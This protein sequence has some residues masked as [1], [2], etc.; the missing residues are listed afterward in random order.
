MDTEEFHHHCPGC[1]EKLND[2]SDVLEHL[3]AEGQSPNNL[4]RQHLFTHHQEFDEDIGDAL[5]RHAG[6]HQGKEA[7]LSL[8]IPHTHAGYETFGRAGI[9]NE[10]QLPSGFQSP[11]FRVWTND[12]GSASGKRSNDRIESLAGGYSHPYSGIKAR[13]FHYK[14]HNRMIG[15]QNNTGIWSDADDY[16]VRFH[17][18][19]IVS[20]HHNG[21]EMSLRG[22]GWSEAPSTRGRMN[23][24]TPRGYRIDQNKVD[25]GS[26]KEDVRNR[27]DED[28]EAKIRTVHHWQSTGTVTTPNDE[29]YPWKD[30]MKFN[31]LT[32][33]PVDK[34]GQPVEPYLECKAKHMFSHYWQDEPHVYEGCGRLFQD[35][36]V[37]AA[38][39][40]RINSR[41]NKAINKRQQET[42]IDVPK[43]AKCRWC[44]SHQTEDHTTHG[45]DYKGEPT[46]YQDK[47]CHRCQRTFYGSKEAGK[48]VPDEIDDGTWGWDGPENF[49]SGGWRR[50]HR[51]EP[52]GQNYRCH[53]CGEMFERG[54]DFH[55]HQKDRSIYSHWIKEHL[56]VYHVA[57]PYAVSTN[58]SMTREDYL[59]YLHKMEHKGPGMFLDFPHNH[60][61]LDADHVRKVIYIQKPNKPMKMEGSATPFGFDQEDDVL[62]QHCSL[63]HVTHGGPGIVPCRNCGHPER[64]HWRTEC[65]ECPAADSSYIGGKCKYVPVDLLPWHEKLHQTRT[66]QMRTTPNGAI[67]SN[68]H[69][70]AGYDTHEKVDQMTRQANPAVGGPPKPRRYSL[71]KLFAPGNYYQGEDVSGVEP[72]V[73]DTKLKMEP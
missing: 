4:F 35:P 72:Y 6:A 58:P 31:L 19:D 68:W 38:H 17:S 24:W 71:M 64:S 50:D 23:T 8:P 66:F 69:A 3:K 53:D 14:G 63:D 52:G 36:D 56:S 20:Y 33:K 34:N 65:E 11:Y 15:V 5:H 10:L 2:W 27:W 48:W 18:T 29:T 16:H 25:L 30:G 51:V 47:F 44:G 39:E 60:V 62:A 37:K 1:N 42:L 55:K 45:K 7:L 12:P 46:S 22:S 9:I 26:K 32:H 54:G 49:T 59:T 67:P 43:N 70:H 41:T 61:G 40:A 13:F 73:A 57:G 28:S 21:L